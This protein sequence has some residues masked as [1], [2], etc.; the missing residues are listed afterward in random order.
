MT[1]AVELKNIIFGYDKRKIVN[2]IS[3]NIEAGS[4]TSIIGPNGSGKST[5]LKII[6]SLI[7]PDNG[8]VRFGGIDIRTMSQLDIARKVAVVPQE[9]NIEYRFTVQ[10][11]VMMGRYPHL[12][13]FQTES[14]SDYKLVG[15]A[16]EMTNT[17]HLKDR[18]INELSGGE[19][20]RVIIA[21]ALAQQ[22]KIILLDEPTSYLDIQHQVEVLE[23]LERLNKEEGLTVIAILHDINLAARFSSN[24]ILLKDGVIIGKGSPKEVIISENLKNAYEIDM[25]ISKNPYSNSPYVIP[26]SKV[27]RGKI[28]KEEKI[29]VICGGGTGT[30]LIQ[31]LT[32]EGYKVTTGVLNIGDSDWEFSQIYDIETIEEAPFTNISDSSYKSNISIIDESGI[33]I[34]TSIHIGPGNLKNLEAFNYALSIGKRVIFLNQYAD[35]IKYDYTTGEGDQLIT[36]IKANCNENYKNLQ[37]LFLNL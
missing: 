28:N 15:N 11:I 30:D 34:L 29:H 14:I 35:Q 20:Q 5:L 31:K 7:S 25:I 21:R 22:P 6:S 17:L 18:Y 27:G 9:N 4:F 23:L 33:V 8:V 32:A 26:L 12:G 19:K 1:I 16:L 3:L 24:M 2:D 37:E 13:R 36:N 10:D